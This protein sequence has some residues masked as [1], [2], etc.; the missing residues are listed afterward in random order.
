MSLTFGTGIGIGFIV[1]GRLREKVA[2]DHLAGHFPV[3]PGARPC[4]CGFSGCFETLCSAARL[5]DDA[6]ALGL[7][8][9]EAVLAAT[10]PEGTAV[11]QAYLGDLSAGLNAIGYIWAPDVIVLGG[12]LG[13]AL[14]PFLGEL[15]RRIFARPKPGYAP[16]IRV[17]GLAEHA[18]ILGAA[19]LLG[20]AVTT[21]TADPSTGRA[22][23]GPA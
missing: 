18:G 3:R 8:G 2:I 9:P 4:Y 12:G 6:A 7:P 22:A 14:S 15:E 17:T 20:D 5:A 19:H 11:T 13:R 23:I 16:A 1:D 21:A 10:T